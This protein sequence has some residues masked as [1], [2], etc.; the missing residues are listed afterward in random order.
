MAL[1][2]T[3]PLC[4]ITGTRLG[5]HPAPSWSP[6]RP[7]SESPSRPSPRAAAQARGCRTPTRRSPPPPGP[8]CRRAVVCLVNRQR[9]ERHLP[10]LRVSPR[11]NRSAQGWTNAM[12]RHDSFT[13]G[14]NFAARITAVGFAGRWPARTSPPGFPPPPQVVRGWMASTGH[15]Q[16]I[17]S[18]AFADV[19][20]GVS[21][22]RIPGFSSGGG[23]WTAGLR[24]ADGRIHAR[25]P[26]T[27]PPAAARTTVARRPAA[28]N[29]SARRRRPPLRVGVDSDPPGAG[30]SRRYHSASSAA[31]QP[32]P[33]AVIAC[34]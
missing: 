9:T 7:S 13:H 31:W 29:R 19:G 27:G 1:T 8:S 30:L 25:R 5:S 16:N 23:T 4:H 3:A 28:G 26:T 12:V 17:L 33:A 20:T 6:R 21:Q 2:D 32:E 18:P 11:L 14:A 10:R 24:P 22:R 15:C 34:R